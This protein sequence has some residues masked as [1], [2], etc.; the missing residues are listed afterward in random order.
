MQRILLILAGVMFVVFSNAF[1]SAVWTHEP[2][3]SALVGE[4]GFNDFAG[5]GWT[6]PWGSSGAIVSDPT[7]PVS[8]PNV[9]KNRRN[10][11]GNWATSISHA[12]S[13]PREVYA[14]F[15]FKPS[16]PHYG[17]FNWYQK[18][19]T[20]TQTLGGNFYTKMQP[21]SGDQFSIEVA[22]EIADNNHN[23]LDA[24]CLR[25]NVNP[26]RFTVGQWCKYEVYAKAS[27]TPTARDGIVAWWCNGELLGYYNNINTNGNFEALFITNIWD[28]VYDVLPYEEW[29]MYDHVYLSL[30][31]NGDPK[32]AYLV[33]T[34][35]LAPA[36]YGVPYAAT[37]A[38]EGGV[39]PY[40]WCLESGNLPAGLL[41]NNNTGV[42][43]GSPTC[44]GRSDFTI[45][46]TD[47]SSPALSATKSYSIVTSG[48]GTCTSGMEDGREPRAAR[49]G[50]EGTMKA[51]SRAGS[52]RF[53]L[54]Q[55]GQYLLGIYSLSGKKM[56]ACSGAGRDEITIK[57]ALGTGVYLA[58]VT[59][60]QRTDMVRFNVMN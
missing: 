12:L 28:A 56:Y 42:I 41:L 49:R 15:A 43:S 9:L 45:R 5:N 46:V 25:Q 23:S 22:F 32:P 52:I 26:K 57:T 36:R 55:H 33:I 27:S 4:W 44:A 50:Q 60:G 6:L 58:K 3:G 24:G 8:P 48:T 10:A 17:W 40:T 59:Q 54:P 37:L 18:L 38:A 34:S 16:N 21:I 31:V 20:F 35:S 30:P 19:A 29:I 53:S 11:S 13:N 2:A 47:A 39:K 7:A 1:S 14:G 51:E